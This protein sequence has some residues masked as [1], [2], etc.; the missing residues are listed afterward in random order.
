MAQQTSTRSRYWRL[1]SRFAAASVVATGIS[2]LV[3]LL[4]YSLGATPVVSTVLA[5]LSGAIPNFV[6]NRRTW[7]G[8]GRAALRGEILRYGA[9]SVGTALLAALATHNAESLATVLF[10]DA[11]AGQ[12]AVVW[13]AFVATYAVMFVVKFFLIDRLVFRR[14]RHQVP[15]TT[16]A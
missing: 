16:R 12:V 7:G 8:G 5:W 13:G 2:Q 3:F 1:L 11:R 6:L 14:S 9:I 15:S 4:S 10:P